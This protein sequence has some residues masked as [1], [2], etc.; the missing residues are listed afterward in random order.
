MKAIVLTAPRSLEVKDLERPRV[1]DD[2]VIVEVKAAG[3][4]GTDLEIYEGNIP[5]KYPR[6]MGH[7]LS[8]IVVDA[9]KGVDRNI[10]GSKVVVD[11]VLYCGKCILCREGLVNLCPNGGLLGRD[12][13]GG[14]AEYVKVPKHNVYPVPS[15]LPFEEA[16]LIQPLTTVVHAV[17]RVGTVIGKSALVIGLGVT[18]LMFVQVLKSI[19]ASPVIGLTR[20]SWKLHLAKDLGA[21]YTINAND[22]S[23][24][25]KVKE[26]TYG[27]GVD[28]VIE[29]SGSRES[30][31]K[32]IKLVKPGGIILRFSTS[33]GDLTLPA[34]DIYFKEISIIGSRAAQPTDWL[35]TLKLIGKSILNTKIFITHMIPLE[36]LEEGIK[37][38][39]SS[40]VNVLKVIV[41]P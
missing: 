28:L 24:Y 21:D 40:D 2:E 27:L 33:K 20:S 1:S 6:I 19:G 9:G 38:L 23:I 3:V 14:F 25:D 29:T 35:T 15:K 32:A 5:V 13:D 18:G 39:R 41:K 10:V 37:L 8:G 26:L 30:F 4:C 11:P 17:K 31:M 22:P 34:Y 12:V 16:T 7:E 36:S